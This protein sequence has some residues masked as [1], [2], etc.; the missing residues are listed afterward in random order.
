MNIV[1]FDAHTCTT[2][3]SKVH[4]PALVGI[5]AATSRGLN[6]SCISWRMLEY[7]HRY[8]APCGERNSKFPHTPR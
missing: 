8:N 7:T 5:W 6:T 3:G 4:V 1:N 2:G